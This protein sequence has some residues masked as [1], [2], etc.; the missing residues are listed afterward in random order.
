MVLRDYKVIAEKSS[1]FLVVAAKVEGLIKELRRLGNEPELLR[2][3]EHIYDGIVRMAEL[4][5]VK[6]QKELEIRAAEIDDLS[7]QVLAFV[8][9]GEALHNGRNIVN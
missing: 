3:F 6:S 4:T 5:Q 1:D 7:A 9:V 2:V 8:E